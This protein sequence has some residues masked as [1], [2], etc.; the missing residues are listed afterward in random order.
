[1]SQKEINDSMADQLA[2]VKNELTTIKDEFKDK[3]NL[4]S[5]EEEDLH[6]V[7]QFLEHAESCDKEGCEVHDHI[8]KV[9]KEW[10]LKGI[11][12]GKRI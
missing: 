9:G 3:T 1:M 10:L 12:I 8:D 6:T 5:Q 4:T 2:Q 11:A 7:N